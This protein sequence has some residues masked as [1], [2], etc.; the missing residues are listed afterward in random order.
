M[1]LFKMAAHEKLNKLSGKENV[2]CS[3][4]YQVLSNET[5]MVG[6]VRQNKKATGELVEYTIE[7]GRNVT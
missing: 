6:V 3:V 2:D 1:P 5:A 7:M 4:K